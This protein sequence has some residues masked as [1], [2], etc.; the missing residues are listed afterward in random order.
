[1]CSNC[2]IVV[3]NGDHAVSFIDGK[4]FVLCIAN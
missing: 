2:Y 3:G 1:M 4:S